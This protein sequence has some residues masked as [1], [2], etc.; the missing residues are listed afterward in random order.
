MKTPED[1]TKGK[2][3][4]TFIKTTESVQG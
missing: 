3:L 1:G 2:Y 4:V